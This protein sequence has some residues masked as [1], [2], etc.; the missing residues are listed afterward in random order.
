MKYFKDCK[1]AEE[2]KKAYWKLAKKLHPDAGGN[3]EEFKSMQA[4]YSAAWDCLKNIHFTKEGKE[5]KKETTETADE[6]IEIIEKLINL[7]GV[8]TEIC[9]S[10]IWCTGDTKPYKDIFK[11]MGFKWAGK[12]EAWFYHKGTFKKHSKEEL[13]MDEIRE[14]YGSVKYVQSEKLA[15]Q[16]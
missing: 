11:K 10:W 9:G 15:L 8:E 6:F 2:L 13:S 14:M 3:E 16:D 4:E 1:T 5:Y 12:K 7:K